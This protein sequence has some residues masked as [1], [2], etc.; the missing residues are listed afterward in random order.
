MHFFSSLVLASP[1][2]GVVLA[3]LPPPAPPQQPGWG[4]ATDGSARLP[5]VPNLLPGSAAAAGTPDCLS[6]SFSGCVKVPRPIH[7]WQ[8]EPNPGVFSAPNCSIVAGCI[9]HPIA[10]RTS[11][12]IF[13]AKEVANSLN[14]V[15]K[16]ASHLNQAGKTY[17]AATCDVDGDGDLDIITIGD[18]PTGSAPFA[19]NKLFINLGDFNFNLQPG[20]PISTNNDNSN[21]VTCVDYNQDGHYDVL[22]GNGNAASE[23]FENQGDGTFVADTSTPITTSTSDTRSVSWGDYD[24]DGL[25]DLL[26]G[27][28]GAANE[29]FQNQGGGT[30]LSVTTTDLT[31]EATSST[32]SV[33]WVDLDGDGDLDVVEGTSGSSGCGTGGGDRRLD[34]EENDEGENEEG[35]ATVNNVLYRN[36]GGGV[37]VKVDTTAFS[38]SV[39]GRSLV[40]IVVGDV[41]GDGLPDIFVANQETDEFYFNKGNFVF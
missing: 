19:S 26:V 31:A 14:F 38:T 13:E 3:A 7:Y 2:V 12:D 4:F 30:F 22:I 25:I 8:N 24:A 6:G 32:K 23:L 28:C 18:L 35:E 17:A 5:P 29:L 16:N 15:E 41:N 40:K 27:N 36:D 37:F 1:F 11:A 21:A 20:S 10:T 9:R 34:E 33:I 39:S